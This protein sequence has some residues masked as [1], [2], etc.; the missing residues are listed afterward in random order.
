MRERPVPGLDRGGTYPV[1]LGGAFPSALL[2]S[3]LDEGSVPLL[4]P[5]GSARRAAGV[6]V[7]V[8][9]V[10]VVVLRSFSVPFSAPFAVVG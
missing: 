1:T 6:E 3:N 8:G 10:N 7:V 4:T 2:G 9:D 5:N